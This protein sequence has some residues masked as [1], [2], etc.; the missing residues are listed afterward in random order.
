MGVELAAGLQR[1]HVPAIAP[2]D[3]QDA[4]AGLQRSV[5]QRFRLL[6]RGI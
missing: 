6:R 4:L 1:E 2:V 3:Q 5:D